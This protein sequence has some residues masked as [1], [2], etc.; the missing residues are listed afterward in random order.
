MK[1]FCYTF[2]TA[3]LLTSASA[4]AQNEIIEN[5]EALNQ[6][7]SKPLM[8]QDKSPVM[9]PENNRAPKPILGVTS[10]GDIDF[11]PIG[12]TRYDLQTNSSM[13]RR[14]INHGNGVVSAIW[15]HSTQNNI[16]FEDRGAG[17]N[18]LNENGEW[19]FG[20]NEVES[21]GGTR[22][23][24][25]N[26]GLTELPGGGMGEYLVTHIASAATDSS[27]GYVYSI[28]DEIGS[29]NWASRP[30]AP[31]GGPIWWR[32]AEA[33][34]GQYR[35]MVGNYSDTS[36]RIDGIQRP[37]VFYRST[38]F[39]ET[40]VDSNIL[41]PGYNEP[42]RF[43]FGTADQ[44]SIDAQDNHVAIVLYH[45]DVVLF[46]S[47]DYG[48][49]F[50][51]TVIEE[52]PLSLQDVED[53]IEAPTTLLCDGSV[54]VM[55]DNDNNP[56]VF[57]GVR[58]LEFTFAS[59]NYG[60]FLRFGP[61]N[62]DFGIKHWSEA[63]GE[64]IVATL[65]DENGTGFNPG[66]A[67]DDFFAEIH[68]ASF[69]NASNNN[70]KHDGTT[71]GSLFRYGGTWLTSMPTAGIDEEGNI[72]M[73]YA[74]S[75]ESTDEFPTYTPTEPAN[76]KDIYVI[77][78]EDN[79][80]T[81]SEPQNIT[82]SAVN[83]EESA[84]PSIAKNVDDK[85]H[86]VFQRDDFPGTAAQGQH[87]ITQNVIYYT[88]LD[89]EMVMNDE[90][91]GEKAIVS[92]QEAMENQVRIKAFPNPVQESYY[93]MVNNSEQINN[94]GYRVLD[95]T[96]KVVAQQ[97]VGQLTEGETSYEINMSTFK[98]GVYLVEF[99]GEGFRNVQKVIKH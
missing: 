39:G 34:N 85:L 99:A 73:V 95:I 13:G 65:F 60:G 17:Y 10:N 79:G 83:M 46:T 81:W 28:N 90:I 55:L 47:D 52:H 57:W 92:V 91:G 36:V 51:K 48:A 18:H 9:L 86:I 12:R 49:T 89:K 41:I 75:V 61:D 35:Y 20:A 97:E 30:V 56:H 23:G 22:S 38:D 40:F 14:I 25:P 29:S 4:F 44:Y 8:I 42:D 53:E 27:G 72:F 77:Y 62:D 31:L 71:T 58:P 2:A 6:L 15:T 24:W 74:S 63:T 93:V 87:G 78:S 37:T 21:I 5:Q 88:G 45:R 33:E 84:F 98:S 82:K 64:K 1:K 19:A 96:G 7:P 80:E 69:I 16:M 50:T 3:A 68:L 66:Q 59:G 94:F 11:V 70:P 32:T 54:H 67:M 76:R 26:I 43:N